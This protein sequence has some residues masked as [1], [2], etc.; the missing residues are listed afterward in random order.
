MTPDTLRR[1]LAALRKR[2]DAYGGPYQWVANEVADMLAKHPASEGEP[3][4]QRDARQLAENVVAECSCRCDEAYKSR[5][6]HGPDCMDYLAAD[7]RALLSAH[8]PDAPSE[9]G[10]S[11]LDKEKET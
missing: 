5:G 7:A 2:L 6:M 8:P 9:P 3:A 10:P 4:G 11:V 1:D